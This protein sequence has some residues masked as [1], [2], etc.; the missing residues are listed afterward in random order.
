MNIYKDKYL[1]YKKKYLNLNHVGGSAKIKD[2]SQQGLDELVGDNTSSGF[3]E[4]TEFKFRSINNRIFTI[5]YRQAKISKLYLKKIMDS[6]IEKNTIDETNQLSSFEYWIG[7]DKKDSVL[8]QLFEYMRLKNGADFKSDIFKIFDKD[9]GFEKKFVKPVKF[10]YQFDETKNEGEWTKN[11]G[12]AKQ[13]AELKDDNPE[14]KA[15][16]WIVNAAKNRSQFYK[17]LKISNLFGISSLLLLGLMYLASLLKFCP[18]GD[19]DRVLDP[20]IT[21]GKLRPMRSK[22]DLMTKA[23]KEEAAKKAEATGADEKKAPSS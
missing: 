23:E 1:K 5:T 8:S 9:G 14:K 20:A 22:A 12:D 3:D 15:M 19:I 11:W 21:D 17:L 16:A 10:G 2:I 18:P 7:V 4:N 6:M 13:F